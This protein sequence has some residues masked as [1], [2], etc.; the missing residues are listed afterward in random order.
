MRP[1]RRKQAREEFLAA[2]LLSRV[3]D[4]FV[5]QDLSGAAPARVLSEA[6][7]QEKWRQAREED[8]A[9]FE[10]VWRDELRWRREERILERM[11][12]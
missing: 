10:R 3:L 9:A 4:E 11:G 8:E 5:S 1:M 12:R 7:S 2:R 6:E